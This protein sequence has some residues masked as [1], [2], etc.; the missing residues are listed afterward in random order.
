MLFRA[1]GLNETTWAPAEPQWVPAYYADQ[2]FAWTPRAV[3]PVPAIRIEAASFRG[4]PT[5]FS[6]IYPWTTPVR[7]T[8]T[9]RSYP[10]MVGDLISVSIVGVLMLA[11]VILARRNVRLDR[12]D[13]K[14][15]LR[16]GVVVGGLVWVSWLVEEHH[17][18][19]T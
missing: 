3:Q 5:S 13:R 2:R 16:L 14:G 4:R 10:Q 7:D 17:V 19:T 9:S 18:A 6:L 12:A 1:A 11:S 8:G 15:A